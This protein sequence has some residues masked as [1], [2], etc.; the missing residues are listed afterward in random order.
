MAGDPRVLAF[1]K[2]I[3]DAALEEGGEDEYVQG[4]GAAEGAEGDDATAAAGATSGSDVNTTVFEELRLS[5][6]KITGAQDLHACAPYRIPKRV[7][8][9]S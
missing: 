8:Q 4:E 7:D 3:L 9:Q 2:G 6:E 5:N 1:F